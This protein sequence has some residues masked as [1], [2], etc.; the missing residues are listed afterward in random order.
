MPSLS[1]FAR[2]LLALHIAVPQS[3]ARSLHDVCQG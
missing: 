1:F 2:L 3:A